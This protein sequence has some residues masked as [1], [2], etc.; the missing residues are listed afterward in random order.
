MQTSTVLDEDAGPVR[1]SV[2]PGGL[3]V[4]TE[5][6]PTVRS[7][8][9]GVWIGIGSVDERPG[10]AGATHYLEHL[11]FKG[12]R[13]RSALDISSE[14]EA[15]GGDINAFTA[16]EFTCYYARV[17]DADLAVAVDVL[18]DMVTS[19]SIEAAEVD[20]ER[21]VVLEE[22]AM[23]DDDP[24]DA[25]H[26]LL[27]ARMWGDSPLGRSI[28]G[29]AE[30]IQQMRRDTVYEYYQQHYRAPN[31]VVTAA[32]NIEHDD[33][34][35]IVSEAFA[36]NG[37]LAGDDLPARARTSGTA[38]GVDSGVTLMSRPIEQ[39]NLLLAMPGLA[40]NDTR[41]FTLGVLN[42]A[43]GG[44]MSSRLFQEIRENRGLAYSVFSFAAQHAAAG[45]FGVYAGC[46]PRKADEVLEVTRGILADVASSG[47]TDDELMRGKGQM[48][49]GLVLGL[50]D[51]SARM[52][53]LAKSELVY[54]E[55]PSI[56]ELLARIDAVT[57]DDV[58]ELASWLLT[59][60]P[61]LAVVGPFDDTSRF[62]SVL[63]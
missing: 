43:L 9:I 8:A 30:S 53:R 57:M 44:G 55:L 42:A 47:I 4:L 60:R 10:E 19:S 59:S 31:I 27:T 38:P 18:A 25:V 16:K 23:R 35:K 14:I 33:V 37:F 11:L 26:D 34:V 51:T 13:R 6:V 24:S 50:E 20:A 48:R 5:A 61:A 28:L 52:S 41:R 7:V 40:R 36:P 49:G 29:T 12:T 63:D 46:H 1:R 45:L 39:A 17:L 56:D 15:V 2:L 54:D 3:R 21:E 62:E 22:I 58:R 32:G